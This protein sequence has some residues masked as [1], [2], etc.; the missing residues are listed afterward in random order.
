M[1]SLP[2][3]F[4]TASLAPKRCNFLLRVERVQDTTEPEAQLEQGARGGGHSW[5]LVGSA[6]NSC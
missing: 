5:P 6:R 3:L 1:A 4:W 2:L